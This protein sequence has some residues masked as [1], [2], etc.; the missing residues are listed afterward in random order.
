MVNK[1]ISR[2]GTRNRYSKRKKFSK[3]RKHHTRKF[4]KR[5]QRRFG[6][7]S[8]SK[9]GGTFDLSISSGDTRLDN[10]N[11]KDNI[12]NGQL[13][14]KGFALVK[15]ISNFISRESLRQVSIYK[16]KNKK[17]KTMLLFVKCNS[18]KNCDGTYDMNVYKVYDMENLHEKD[19]KGSPSFVFN[20]D[21]GEGKYKI[22]LRDSEDSEDSKGFPNSAQDGIVQLKQAIQEQE[23]EKRQQVV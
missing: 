15:K 7:L 21:N 2:R 14:Y 12:E 17:G 22:K 8:R 9:K 23:N 19:D 3:Y 20:V 18:D 10:M 13:I 11:L 16:Y 6:K 1:I 5:F 4:G